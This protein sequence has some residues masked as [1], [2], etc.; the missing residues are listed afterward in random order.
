MS[1]AS[2]AL[3]A[4]PLALARGRAYSL[5]GRLFQH[6]LNPETTA[7]VMA[8]PELAAE[9]P[10]LDR[11]HQP[12]FDRLAADHYALF[13]L[14]VFPHESIFL[15][16]ESTLGGP[17]TGEVMGF[18]QQAGFDFI[19]SGDNPDHVGLELGLLAFLSSAEADAWEDGQALVALRL[20]ELQRRFLD[21][22]LLRWLPGLNLAIRQQ[23]EPFYSALAGLTLELAGEH[24][25]GLAGGSVPDQPGFQLPPVLD[26]LSD[27]KTGL[28]EIARYLL[29]PAYSGLYLSREDISRLASGLGIPRGFG[30]REQ[31]LT[32]L[33]RTAADYEQLPRLVENLGILLESWIEFYAGLCGD[34]RP[35]DPFAAPWLERLNHT[36]ALLAT[37]SSQI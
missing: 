3:P 22:H 32:N 24:R 4:G 10:D 1:A 16:I 5:F 35:L 15:D 23:G 27:E 36:Q 17:V 7:P 29:T 18:Y 20:R 34:E 11:A 37:V 33:L 28:K 6:G 14:N 21:G 25:S 26:V 12:D 2:P 9:I 8:I 31:M 30:S 13:G 19:Q